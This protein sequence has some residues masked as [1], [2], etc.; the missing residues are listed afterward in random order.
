MT[1]CRC[2]DETLLV[3]VE[4]DDYAETHLVREAVGEG[5]R[6][7]RYRCPQT[8][9]LW[10]LDIDGH[11]SAGS[12]TLRLRRLMTTAELVEFLASEP[13]MQERLA[14]TDPDVEFRLVGDDTIYR[15]LAEARRWAERLDRGRDVPRAQALSMVEQGDDVVVFGSVAEKRD[16]RY[17]EHR[18]AAWLLTSR[19]GRLVRSLWFDSWEAAREAVGLPKSGGPEPT[20]LGNAFLWLRQALLHPRFA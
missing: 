1:A 4:A 17:V 10:V 13:P 12:G 8:K 7:V 2:D 3:G 9:R 19:N 16:G 6:E 11:P 20:K 5:A 15:G 14:F 18:P